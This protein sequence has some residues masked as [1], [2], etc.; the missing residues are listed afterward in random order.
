MSKVISGHNKISSLF[1]IK[2]LLNEDLYTLVLSFHMLSA[3]GKHQI[4]DIN[5]Q[6][7]PWPKALWCIQNCQCIKIQFFL[8]ENMFFPFL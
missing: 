5:I 2:S 8:V 6:A 4:V 1:I 3:W 7:F